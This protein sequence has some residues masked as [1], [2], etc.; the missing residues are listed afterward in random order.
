MKTKGKS[1]KRK[2]FNE[3]VS[4]YHLTSTSKKQNVNFDT[5][6]IDSSDMI[7]DN[8]IQK[9]LIVQQSVHLLVVQQH[10][11][12][13]VVQQHVQPQ[14]LHMV[15]GNI[16]EK[17]LATRDHVDIHGNESKSMRTN[18]RHTRCQQQTINSHQ[19]LNNETNFQHQLAKQGSNT[20]NTYINQALNHQTTAQD[21]YLEADISKFKVKLYNVVGT[22]E[23]ELPTTES[24]GAIVFGET[25]SMENDFDLIVKQH[26]R[27]PQQLYVVTAYCSIEQRSRTI[28]TASFTGGPRYMYS[29][30]LDALAIC[31]VHGN[32]S[33][34]ITFTCNAKWPEILEYMDSFPELT[35]ADRAVIVD[36][37]FERKIRDYVKFIRNERPFGDITA[38]LY[39]IE[40]QKRR[41]PHCHSLLW[42]FGPSKVREGKDVDRYISAELPDPA[43]DVEG[44]R[45]VSEL[46]MQWPM[47]TY[48]DDYGYVHYRRRDTGIDTEKQNVRLDNTYVVPYNRRLCMRYYAHINVEY[49]GWTML[50]KYLFKYISKGTDRV[51]ANITREI[52]DVASTSIA[53]MIQIDEIK[54]FVDA[55]YIGPH[56]ACWRILNFDIHYRD[57]AV[58]ILAVHLENMQRVT[59]K[60]KDNLQTVFNNPTKKKTTLTEWLEWYPTDKYWQRRHNLNKSSIGRLTYVHPSLGEL[61][62]E[63]ILLCHQ[64]G[65]KNFNDIRTVNDTMYPTNRAACEALG[66][67]NDDQEWV[68]AL[69]EAAEHAT[70]A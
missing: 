14:P 30:Y 43:Q 65:C 27:F 51:V 19:A 55:R 10:V 33:F 70:T 28:L 54:N 61:F 5:V 47:C 42:I 24:V 48:I 13:S 3:C 32:P 2:L 6:A 66:L 67:L 44:Y 46:M 31:R 23:Y 21:K 49:C 62:H 1:V 25:S 17:D 8:E 41:L 58:Q 12:P 50:I 40:F 34:F 53:P 68:C 29:H 4:D 57:P 37:V 69:K 52:G 22:Q 36:H 45:I 59:F 11:Q 7:V 9:P 39:T 64:K 63:R 38:V 18:R 20:K 60:S 35:P 16:V 26:S 56:E 15:A